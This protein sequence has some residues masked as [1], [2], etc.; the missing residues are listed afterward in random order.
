MGFRLLPLMQQAMRR[1]ERPLELLPQANLHLKAAD[2]PSPRLRRASWRP[3]FLVLPALVTRPGPLP[4][5]WPV[6]EKWQMHLAR[7]PD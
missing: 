6:R 7:P 3:P 5:K 2:P 1:Q 4:A